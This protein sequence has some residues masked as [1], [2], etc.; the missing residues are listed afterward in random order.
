ML[1]VVWHNPN[2]HGS[3]IHFQTADP[4]SVPIKTA[5]AV[6]SQPADFHRL[7]PRKREVLRL[8]SAPPLRFHTP[9]AASDDRCL[10]GDSLFMAYL[11]PRTKAALA[12]TVH[13]GCLYPATSIRNA[14]FLW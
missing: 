2:P 7:R 12:R 11:S 5:K 8:R 13:L 9:G 4:R 10:E 14:D 1:L 3:R 6:R